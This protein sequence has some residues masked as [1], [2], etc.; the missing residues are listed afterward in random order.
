MKR[1]II[2][3]LGVA[4]VLMAL[5]ACGGGGGPRHDIINPPNNTT[6]DVSG[7]LTDS[8]GNPIA[9]ASVLVNGTDS[10][11]QTDSA[12][13]FVIPDVPS[14]HSMKL[15][16][17]SQGVMLGERDFIPD[18]TWTFNWQIGESDPNGGT[19]NGLVYDSADNSPIT[20]AMLVL[21]SEDWVSI[22]GTDENGNFEFT[23]VPAGDYQIIVFAPNYRLQMKSLNVESGN[24][25][26]LSIALEA[27]SN[28][29]PD[30]GYTVKGRVTDSASGNGVANVLVQGNSDN[31]WYYICGT[32]G[33]SSSGTDTRVSQEDNSGEP[34]TGIG[35]DESAPLDSN[36]QSY[37]EEP[38]YQETYT[39]A[40][41]YYEFPDSFNGMGVYINTNQEDYMPASGYFA[42]E[43]DGEVVANLQMNPIVPVNISGTVTNEAGN[44]IEG[45]YVEFIY[46]D[47]NFYGYDYA[48]PAAGGLENMDAGGMAWA[49][50]GETDAALPGAAPA[51]GSGGFDQTLDSYGMAK[52]RQQMRDNRGA[53]QDSA[54]M[55][56]G[57]YAT[58]TDENGHYDLGSIPA[59]YY[60]V[61][62]SA[63]GYLGY[64]QEMELTTDS[65][66]M[67][68]TLED[69]PVGSVTGTVCD[70]TGTPIPDALVN[71]TQ[72]YVDPFTFTDENGY[73]ELTNVPAGTWRV[74]AYKEGYSARATTVDITEDIVINLDFTL[75]ADSTPP[76]TDLVTLT[77][78]V[79]DGSTNEAIADADIVAVATDDSY[80]SYVTSDNDGNYTLQLPA[81]EYNVLVESTDYQDV[82]IR[83]WV[84]PEWPSY[85]FYMWPKN[86]NGGGGWGNIVDGRVPPPTEPPNGEE[87]GGPPQGL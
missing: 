21:F 41:G 47:P 16:V 68:F 72:P 2:V 19:V 27:S 23:G 43:A 70:D 1:L 74:G 4:I 80:H 82:Y 9:E 6:H 40:D 78:K 42:R 31:G 46:V 66:A 17:R 56:F 11:I 32:E 29:T 5:A 13:N 50:T 69:V 28:T 65:D 20:D 12:G 38:V 64:G 76:P 7:T 44:P 36:G 53:S 15:G 54:P 73:F 45:A 33:S 79:L 75:P 37:W 71:A 26:Q 8:Y 84:D 22:M 10:G 18:E 60:S 83:V 67:D 24:T 57:Y 34:D 55:P 81:G 35:Y 63:F 87:P 14:G 61:F 58:S 48:V 59:G 85:D 86:Y 30:D 49:S 77:G 62:V 39:D 52:Y 25:T 3:V 51:E